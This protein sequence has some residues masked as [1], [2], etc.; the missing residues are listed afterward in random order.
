[1][2]STLFSS[3]RWTRVAD[4]VGIKWRADWRR[5]DQLGRSE[6]TRAPCPF[7]CSQEIRRSHQAERAARRVA[8]GWSRRKSAYLFCRALF[9]IAFL[10]SFAWTGPVWY[11]FTGPVPVAHRC[12]NY[13]P[14][15]RNHRFA[16]A[17]FS[18]I[19]SHSS[20]NSLPSCWT[21][22]LARTSTCPSFTETFISIF[23]ASSV[24]S[25]ACAEVGS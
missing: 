5:P 21:E 3:S 2:R 16:F 7:L 25:S 10:E 19:H 11:F 15:P 8:R 6:S 18:W 20:L 24:A 14:L 13:A 12:V 9:A 4:L 23:E 22:P 17:G 1:M